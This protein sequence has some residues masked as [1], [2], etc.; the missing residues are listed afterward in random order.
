[1]VDPTHEE[2]V[3]IDG[4]LILAMNVHREICTLQMT[5]GVA[6]L[7]DQVHVM[8]TSSNVMCH[9]RSGDVLK[10]PLL[11]LVKLMN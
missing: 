8:M 2:E 3:V 4:R 5:G 10:L 11:K 1:M 7:P 6:L 9:H